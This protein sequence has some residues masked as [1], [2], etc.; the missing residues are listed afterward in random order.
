MKDMT[1]QQV[2]LAKKKLHTDI[3]ALMVDFEQRTGLTIDEIRLT[4]SFSMGNPRGQTA[5]IEIE[6]KL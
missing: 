1:I 6:V 5:D 2:G 4:H 3:L